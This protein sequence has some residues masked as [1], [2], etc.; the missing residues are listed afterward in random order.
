VL[1]ITITETLTEKRCLQGRLV[2]PWVGELRTS[3][4]KTHRDQSGRTCIL[5]LKDVTFLTKTLKNS[6]KLCLRRV[7]NSLPTEFTSSRCLNN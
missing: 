4:E 2:G 3:W 5:D 1:K 6:C 7:R